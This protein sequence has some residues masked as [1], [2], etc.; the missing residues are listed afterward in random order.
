V[1]ELHAE[2]RINR[3]ELLLRQH[4]HLA[5]DAE[6]FR[7]AALEFDEFQP[8]RLKN[9]LVGFARGVDK[10]VKPLHFGNRIG[11]ERAESRCF[12]QPTS[13]LPNCVPQSPMWCR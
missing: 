9:L 12:F 4:N 10:L 2:P 5:P 8:R 13:N 7:V 6:V 11:L 1:V 3:V